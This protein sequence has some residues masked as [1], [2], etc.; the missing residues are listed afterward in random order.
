M[1]DGRLLQKLDRDQYFMLLPCGAA[2]NKQPPPPFAKKKK[3]KKEEPTSQAN[4][5]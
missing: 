5:L 4:S 3:K 2:P 1:Y